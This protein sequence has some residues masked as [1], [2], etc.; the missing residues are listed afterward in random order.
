MANDTPRNK[1]AKPHP[2]YPL[3]AHNSGRWAKKVRQKTHFFG[4][5]EDPQGALELWLEQKDALLAGRKPRVASANELSIRRMCDLFMDSRHRMAA[6]GELAETTLADYQSVV[7]MIADHFGRSTPVESLTPADFSEFRAALGIG[8]N[9]KTLEGRIAC[10][11]AVFNHADRNGFLERSLSKIWGTEFR[12]PS[13]TALTKLANQT[14]RLFTAAE[15][16]SLLT[17]APLHLKAMILLGLNAGLG[18]TDIALM[19]DSDIKSGWL[20]LPRNKTGKHRRIPLWDETLLA[21]ESARKVRPRAKDPADDGLCFIT[22]YGRNWRPSPK[23]F[24]LTAEFTKLKRSA[25][26]TG[27]GK[28]FYTLR[29]T[30]QTIGDESRDFVAVSSLMGHA[31]RTISDHYREK[32]SDQRL[33]AVTNLV[34]DWLWPRPTTGDH[35]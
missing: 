15:V 5:W 7:L 27:K 13:R 33:L 6:T 10:A 9:L 12:K 23:R 2:N 29:H 20:E 28:S 19:K 30:L 14:Q 8:C 31:G 24:P 1:P 17:P 32:I 34:H 18:P 26:I 16:R 22:K 3:Y 35:Q 11:R 4:K 25:G 21:I